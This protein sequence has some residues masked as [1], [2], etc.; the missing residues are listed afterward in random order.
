MAKL[1]AWTICFNVFVRK[2]YFISF[3]PLRSIA[4]MAIVK[5][6]GL[7]VGKFERRVNFFKPK[8]QKLGMIVSCRNLL[9]FFVTDRHFGVIPMTCKEWRATSGSLFVI[10]VRKFR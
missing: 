2:P 8:T 10:V 6:L 9:N 1:S 5:L 3:V 4:V 7:L